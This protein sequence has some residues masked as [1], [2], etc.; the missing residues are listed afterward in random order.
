[1]KVNVLLNVQGGKWGEQRTGTTPPMRA[2]ATA[3][4]A[5][6]RSR[7]LFSIGQPPPVEYLS[8]DK[9]STSLVLKEYEP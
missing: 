2:A 1:L 6:G 5:L 3:D 4:T 9:R 7:P 8:K